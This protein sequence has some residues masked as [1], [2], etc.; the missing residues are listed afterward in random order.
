M[1][2]IYTEQSKNV[3]KTWLIMIVFISTIV[4]VGYLMAQYFGNPTFLYL[5]VFMSFVMNI[6]SYW[7]SDSL[8]LSASG[9]KA[10][11]REESPELWNIVENL[12]IT[13]GLPM[14]RVYVIP[15]NAPNA[16]AT[17]RNAKHAAV[18]VTSGLMQRLSRAELEGVIAHELSHIGNKDILIM[19]VASVLVGFIAI[20]ADMMGRMAM[21]GG[22]EDREGGVHPVAIVVGIVIMLLGPLAAQLMQLAISRKR[23]FLADATGA[24]LTRYPEGLA[25][26]LE[27]IAGYPA[28]MKRA[29]SATAHMFISNP[30]GAASMGKMMSNLFSTHPPMEDR[31]A[32]LRSMG[33]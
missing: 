7:F 18:A 31:V 21:F 12:S 30:F 17:G 26:A 28:P 23:E 1:T 13:A 2:S 3:R 14:P 33:V 10:T 8:A 27:K 15:D 6:G 11:T 19:S 20:I 24:L 22:S 9:A 16:F 4:G 29:N 25:S 32:R 5:A